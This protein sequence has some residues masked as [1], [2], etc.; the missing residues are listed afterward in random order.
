MAVE[1]LWAGAD[2]QRSPFEF[3]KKMR[4]VDMDENNGISDLVCTLT[5]D[6]STEDIIF[7][8][9]ASDISLAVS[10]KRVELNITQAQYA[11]VLGVSRTTISRWESA[12]YN[13]TLKSLI[14]LA[15]KLGLELRISLE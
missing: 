10:K 14:S 4:G 1:A 7:A 3:Y 13:C 8:D 15:Q 2:M 5:K 6:L 11:N 12:G 9:I